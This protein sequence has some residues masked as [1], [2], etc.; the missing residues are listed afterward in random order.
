MPETIVCGVDTSSATDS[1]VETASWL[2]NRLQARLVLV[3]VVEEPM[4]EAEELVIAIRVRLGLGARDDIRLLEGSPQERL[5]QTVD[6]DGADLLVV[7]SRGRGALQ[8]AVFGSVSRSLVTSAHCPVVVVPPGLPDRNSESGDEASIV[9]G[10][11]GSDHAVAAARLAADLAARLGFR[12]LVVHALPDLGAV[13]SYPGARST[14]PPL[15]AQPDERARHA[16]R[17]I[18]G[19]VDAAAGV[20]EGIVEAGRPWEVLE[21]VADREGGELLPA[22]ARGLSGLRAAM[23]GS[24]ANEVVTSFAS[25]RHSPAGARREPHRV[26]RLIAGARREQVQAEPA[27]EERGRELPL[28]AVPGLVEQRRERA[29]AALAGGDCDDAAADAALAR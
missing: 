14:A 26:E 18:D 21:S 2:A 19:A 6:E 27:R 25:A 9:C 22:A 15:S 1:V 23:F 28:D 17:I 20:A 4:A 12:L 13:A 16:Q 7:G 5:Q 10:V 8:S 11:D 24:V 29:E 3:H